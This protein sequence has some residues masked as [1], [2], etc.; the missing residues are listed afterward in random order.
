[1]QYRGRPSRRRPGESN[2]LGQS[3]GSENVRALLASP[4][5][6]GLFWAAGMESFVLKG[7]EIGTSVADAYPW[8]AALDSLVNCDTAADVLACL[9]AVPADTLV[10][11]SINTTE[12]GWV[13]IEP[14]V[15]P[16]DPYDKPQRLGFQGRIRRQ[17]GRTRFGRVDAGLGADC[18]EPK[19]GSRRADQ[20]RCQRFS[21]VSANAD[22]RSNKLRRTGG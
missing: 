4:A 5:A 2:D 10:Q 11:T 9:R 7:G 19:A 20:D 14:T 16:E 6:A 12:S 15:L 18:H 17:W 22:C 13:N 1:M 3:A 21:P 8:Y